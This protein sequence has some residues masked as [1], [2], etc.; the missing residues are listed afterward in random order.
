M[1]IKVVLLVLD[2]EFII[3]RLPPGEGE[4]EKG[5][6][7]KTLSGWTMSSLVRDDLAPDK[8]IGKFSAE[9]TALE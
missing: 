4:Y 3:K 6:A 9:H 5:E 2:R 7:D 1:T 8:R